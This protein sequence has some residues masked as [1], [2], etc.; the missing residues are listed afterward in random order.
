M[1]YKQKI[2]MKDNITELHEYINIYLFRQS[3][4]RHLVVKNHQ[5]NSDQKNKKSRVF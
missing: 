5:Q 1:P 3:I 4:N 2:A